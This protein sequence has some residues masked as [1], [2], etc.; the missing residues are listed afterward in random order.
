MVSACPDRSAAKGTDELNSEYDTARAAGIA[1]KIL[2][3]NRKINL[4][5]I[6]KISKLAE[7]FL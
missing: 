1:Q 3:P 6:I 4:F 5:L 7:Q 2:P